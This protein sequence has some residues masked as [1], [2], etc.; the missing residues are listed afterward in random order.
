M[1][2]EENNQ[3]STSMKKIAE[4]LSKERRIGKTA[5]YF[6]GEEITLSGKAFGCKS[7]TELFSIA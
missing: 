3:R 5:I 2:D 6:N 7:D 1:T 4:A